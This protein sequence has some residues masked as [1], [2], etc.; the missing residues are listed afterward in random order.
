MDAIVTTEPFL[1]LLTL[2]NT[3][4][5]TKPLLDFLTLMDAIR[6]TKPFLD[7][8]TLMDAIVTAEPLLDGLRLNI[9]GLD[10]VWKLSLDEFVFR[11]GISTLTIR[12]DSSAVDC[13]GG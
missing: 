11:I 5:T 7:L 12:H 1:N 3:V 9:P 8:F 10:T 6:S 2:V 4:R 13:H